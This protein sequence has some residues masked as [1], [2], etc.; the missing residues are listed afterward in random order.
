M[1][2][3]I[4]IIEDEPTIGKNMATYL[5]RHGFEVRLAACAEAGLAEVDSF[6]PDIVVLD[7]NLPGMNGIEAL[8]RLRQSAGEIKTIMITGHGSVEL[9]V[10]AMK[11][12]AYDFLTKPVSLSQLK[13]LLEKALGQERMEEALSYYRRKEQDQTRFNDTMLGESVK[14]CALKQTIAQVLA[15]ERDLADTDAPAVLI[16][17][18]TGTGKEVVARALHAGGP[19]SSKPFVEINCASIPAQLLESELFGHERGA[20]TDAKE[21]KLGLVETADGGTL[22]LDEIGDMD[23]ALQAKLLKLLEEKTVRRIGSLRDY[24]VNIRIIA[25]TH[26]PLEQLAQEGKF[27]TDLFFR[28]RIIHLQ[29]P[30]LR[31][32]GNDILLLA[33]HFL[34][35]QGARYRKPDLTLSAEVQAILARHRWSGNVRELRYI[36]EQAVLLTRGRTIEPMHIN[37]SASI[38]A[39]VDGIVATD[40]AFIATERFP[41]DGLPLADV[42]RGLLLKAL[43]RTNWNVTRAGKLLGLSR[44]TM[45]YR[46]DK[47]Q[48]TPQS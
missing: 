20:F 11:A 17:G 14:M 4:L 29:V 27:R 40:E 2:H 10:E 48:L 13:L 46:I 12:G 23:L 7:F 44:D 37:L 34:K 33:N 32:R 43:H 1:S 24:R 38:V 9:A 25:A 8:G 42:E 22:F 36:I 15:A 35:V 31:E 39:P 28:L 18:E 5:T 19:R 47:F 26:R 45:R 30:P 16:T 3:A 21:R 41:A 6:K